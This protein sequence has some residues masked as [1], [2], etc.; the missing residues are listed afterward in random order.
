MDLK[1]GGVSAFSVPAPLLILKK[2]F[3]L[4]FIPT[5]KYCLPSSPY[6]K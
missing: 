2:D 6:S 3:L 4:I 1:A 5:S